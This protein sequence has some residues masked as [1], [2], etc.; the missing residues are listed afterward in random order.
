V[1]QL[2]AATGVVVDA[3]VRAELAEDLTARAAARCVPL[4]TRDGAPVP[5]PEHIRALTSRP[6]LAVE[7]DWPSGS[8]PAAPTQLPPRPSMASPG[9]PGGRL[10]G[11]R[12]SPRWPGT[13]SCWW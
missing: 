8:P 10:V 6:V 3:A 9:Q 7:A 12:S 13:G 5:V 4:L 11:V 2:I 1:E